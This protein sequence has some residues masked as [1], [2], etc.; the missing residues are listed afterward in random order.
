M[1]TGICQSGL[2]VT[3]TLTVCIAPAEPA[4]EI[5][6]LF[7]IHQENTNKNL[8]FLKL[9]FRYCDITLFL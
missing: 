3:W 9:S 1:K 6:M 5:L 2:G 8:A 4:T 7:Q